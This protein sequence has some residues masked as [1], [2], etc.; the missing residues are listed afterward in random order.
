MKALKV[1]IILLLSSPFASYNSI[2]SEGEVLNTQGA[3]TGRGKSYA[4]AYI[5]ASSNIPR[6]VMVYSKSVIRGVNGNDWV[7][8]LF[9]R[10]A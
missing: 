5:D 7:I 9:W 4:E 2:A 10:R 8:T 1:F 6:N 3:Y